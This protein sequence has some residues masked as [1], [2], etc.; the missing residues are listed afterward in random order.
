M[1]KKKRERERERKYVAMTRLNPVF[2]GVSFEIQ[3]TQNDELVY[4]YS[5][6]MTCHNL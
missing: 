1:K 2:A 6:E 4:K 5:A 3:A